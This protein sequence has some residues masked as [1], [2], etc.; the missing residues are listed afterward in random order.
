MTNN[1]K[2]KE[3]AVVMGHMSLVISPRS[4]QSLIEVLIGLSI[5]AILIGAATIAISS[6][7]QSNVGIERNQAASAFGQD[8]IDKTRAWGDENWRNIYDLT[9]GTS[10][11]Y[12]LNASGSTLFVIQGAEGLIDNDVTGSMV[13]HLKFDEIVT[14]TSTTTHDATGNNYDGTIVGASRASSTCR[15]GS[16]LSFDGTND[17][18]SSGNQSNL[19]ATS[20]FS[21]SAWINRQGN[22]VAGGAGTIAGKWSTA[23]NAGWFLE[24]ID[25][26]DGS[27]PNQ[28]RFFI[29]GVSDTSLYSASSTITNSAWHHV[30]AAYDG[31]NKYIYV[32][33][34]PASEATTGVPTT[35]SDDFQVGFDTG[36]GGENNYF[37][38]FI[39]DVRVYTKALSADEVKHLYS[40]K[41]FSR[42]FSIENTCRTSDAS[43]TISGVA[44]C[45]AGT[46]A[47]PST[48]KITAIVT[49][50]GND[51]TIESSLSSFV[52]RWQNAVF[53][54][55]DWSQGIDTSGTYTRD[56]R[57][58]SSS[59]NMAA[60]SSPGSL[61]IEGL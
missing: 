17:S 40:G 19:N 28:I 13:L 16:C 36:S 52:T 14:S 3:G 46:L 61:K 48:Q 31:S 42:S 37:N 33:G 27:N 57:R 44:P 26:A 2:T 8:L 54:Q 24:V 51:G 34:T 22:S 18:V 1:R 43:S 59:S 41:M 30:V 47:D 23:G 58:Y 38:G 6:I 15:I 11:Q 49:W 39:D 29:S 25:S 9:K 20:T 12:F 53:R 56:T 5:G 7:L 10:T 4:G 50:E 45:P 21:V 55:T 32:D 60:T 35:T